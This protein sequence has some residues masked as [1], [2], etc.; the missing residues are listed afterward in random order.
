MIGLLNGNNEK[1][2]RAVGRFFHRWVE[3]LLHGFDSSALE[4]RRL[5]PLLSDAGVEVGELLGPLGGKVGTG[6]WVGLDKYC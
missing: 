5:L 2:S 1:I 6:F 3:V 4:F